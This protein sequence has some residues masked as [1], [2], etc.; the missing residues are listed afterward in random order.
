MERRTA[1]LLLVTA[2]LSLLA[3]AGPARARTAEKPAAPPLT[4]PVLVDEVPA[5][6]PPR[7]IE[8][9]VEAEVVL[10]IDIDA[11]GQVEGA[12]VVVPAAPGGYGFDEAAL[13]AVLAFGF[14]PAR[15]GDTPV[16]VRITYRYRFAL[17]SEGPVQGQEGTDPSDRSDP[18]DRSDRPPSPPEPQVN[19]SGRLLERGTRVPLAGIT[20]VVFRGE[21]REAAGFETETDADGVFAFF[22][23]EP[24]PWRVLA[25]PEGYF[26]LR[27]TEQ[28]TAGERVEAAYFVERGTYSPYDVVVEGEREL[29]EVSRVSLRVE[30]IERVPGTFGDVLAVVQNLPGVARPAPFSGDIIVRGSAPEDTQIFVDGVGVPIIY[31]F[32]GVRSVIPLR[33]LEGIDFYPGNYSVQYGR[34]TGGLVDV[35]LKR[36]RP[37]RL[38]GEI[39]VNLVDAG[40]F[41]EA[42]LGD[43]WA[44]AVAGR[45]SYI[46]GLIDAFAPD[47]LSVGLVTAPRYYDGQLLL[48]FRPSPAHEL[49]AFVFGSDDRLEVLF[50][51]P[52]DIDPELSASDATTSTSFYRTLLEY[53]F[54]PRPEVRNVLRA[55]AGRNWIYFGVGDQFYLDLNTYVAQIRDTLSL[56]LGGAL[57]VNAGFDYVFSRTDA[58]FKLPV[59]SKEGEPGGKPELDSVRFTEADGVDFHS[60]GVFL[61]AEARF[62]DRL[63]L[64][65]GVRFDRF[66][67]VERSALAPRLAARLT[68]AEQWVVKGGVGLFHQEPA[69]DETDEVFGNPALDLESAWHYSAGVEFRPLPQLVLDATGFYKDIDDLVSRTA[70]TVERGGA[71]VPLNFDNGGEGR[72]YGLELLVRHEPAN[73]FSGW[74][75]YTLSRAERRDSGESDWRLFDYDQTHILTLV[76]TYDLPRNWSVGGRFRLVSGNPYTPRTGSVYVVDDGNYQPVFGAANS[77]RYP[78]FHQLDIRVDKRWILD[79]WVL[80][81]YLDLQNAYNQANTTGFSYN[82]DSS[83][84]RARTGLPILPVIGLTGEF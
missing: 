37:E 35:N 42:P 16:P 3:A 27:T 31:H 7:A 72:V 23:L 13:A 22:D 10:E 48:G 76:G 11:E 41:L 40:A 63:L 74:I 24:G 84:R 75:S 19:F 58:A 64:V 73:D 69:F 70:D 68:V 12:N 50:E 61:E 29:K 17:A 81:A 32:G 46:D 14:E 71:V 62:F 56:D 39:D 77:E 83:E 51:N 53:R 15:E 65:P 20:V 59:S 66:S 26:P 28:V 18:T 78:L 1:R 38:S 44:V 21:G 34:G 54:T 6:Y 43:R 60:L 33:M 5:V 49:R 30:E 55:S 57:T 2:G 25:Q 82:Y 67:R 8:D 4:P 36:Q 80:T 47:D 52:A 79:H 9:R 45:R